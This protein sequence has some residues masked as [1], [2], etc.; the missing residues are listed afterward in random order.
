[1]PALDSNFTG[2]RGE[3]MFADHFICER[4]FIAR[5]VHDLWGSDY[6]VEW[7]GELHKVNVKTMSRRKRDPDD[8]IVNLHKSN[9]ASGVRV[10]TED[11]VTYFGVVNLDESRIWMIPLSSVRDRKGIGYKGIAYQ[12]RKKVR[13]DAFEWDR[14]RIK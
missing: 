9:Q 10:Y 14:Y 6:C 2:A 11:E 4:K 3:Q 13:S 8:Y 1:M 7:G 12:R 5:P